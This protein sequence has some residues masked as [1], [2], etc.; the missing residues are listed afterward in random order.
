M[1]PPVASHSHREET[2]KGWTAQRRD[3]LG[4][5]KMKPKQLSRIRAP[6][7]QDRARKGDDPPYYVVLFLLNAQHR[8]RHKE[9]A[10]NKFLNF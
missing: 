9:C 2:V 10:Q 3:W 8:A 5:W 4:L 7:S 6:S 1:V